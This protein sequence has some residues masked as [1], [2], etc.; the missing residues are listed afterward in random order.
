[1]EEH[2]IEGHYRILSETLGAAIRDGSAPWLRSWE[3]GVSFLPLSLSSDDPYRGS[4][5][6]ALMDKARKKGYEDTYW[7]TFRGA[8]KAGGHVRKGEK[9]TKV[10][11]P[12]T[13]NIRDEHGQLVFDEKGNPKKEVIDWS[14][15]SVFNVEQT[16]GLDR[17]KLRERARLAIKKWNAQE[18]IEQM[19]QDIGVKVTHQDGDHVTAKYDY[20]R[21]LIVLP[22]QARFASR[23]KYYQTKLH[24][25]AHATGHKSR[26]N[27]STQIAHDGFDSQSY[28]KEELCVEIATMITG[29]R[30]GIG[31]EPRHGDR[32]V[33]P[34]VMLLDSEQKTIQEV[35]GV[36][37]KISDWL[38]ERADSQD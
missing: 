20:D 5:I 27:R 31:H 19:I 22:P 12:R 38:L 23:T 29:E 26:L 24:E 30:I 13:K 15:L 36:A 35:S 4:N 18:Q 11:I 25:L 21:D 17:E 16:D 34:W 9:S 14:S 6:F 33:E 3:P 37:Q 7:V 8:L 2:W 32:Y 10:V 28:A 1:M